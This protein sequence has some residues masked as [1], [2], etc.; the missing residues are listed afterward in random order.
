MYEMYVDS[1]SFCIIIDNFL[2]SPFRSKSETLHSAGI[3]ALKCLDGL[4][5]FADKVDVFLYFSSK[6]NRSM[7]GIPGT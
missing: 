6:S 7:A 5:E 4:T 2:I 3:S 1:D